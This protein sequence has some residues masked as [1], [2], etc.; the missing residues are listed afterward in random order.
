LVAGRCHGGAEGVVIVLCLSR[1]TT[2]NILTILLRK[3]PWA[4]IFSLGARP[5]QGRRSSPETYL[6]FSPSVQQV[7]DRD[8]RALFF[9]GTA[10]LDIV[11]IKGRQGADITHHI[12]TI[13]GAVDIDRRPAPVPGVFILPIQLHHERDGRGQRGHGLGPLSRRGE[14]PRKIRSPWQR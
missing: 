1:L 4:F 10:V 9:P 8:R 6:L 14:P 12:E 5:S 2:C 13:I 3:Q 7:E 11:E